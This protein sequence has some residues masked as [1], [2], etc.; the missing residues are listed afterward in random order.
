MSRMNRGLALVLGIFLAGAT[1]AATPQLAE[2]VVAVVRGPGAPQP[3]VITL[4]RLEEEARIALVS[5]GAVAA[6]TAP[7]DRAALRATLEW[8]VDQTLLGDEVARL[9][10]LEVA[11]AEVD[12]ALRRFRERFGRPADYHAFLDR[13]ELSDDDVAAVLRRTIRVQRYLES[14]AGRA[15]AVSDAEVDAWITGHEKETAGVDPAAARGAVR[16]RLSQERL[17]RQVRAVVA[18]LRGRSDVRILEDEL[19]GAR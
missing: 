3:R 4:T 18:D 14:R 12:E 2:E 19:G 10:I 13:L 16:A 9:Q 7:L 11:P 17:E 6:A 8:L 5:R 15:A 1:P